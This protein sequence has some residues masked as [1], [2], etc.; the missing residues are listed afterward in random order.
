MPEKEMPKIEDIIKHQIDFESRLDSIYMNSKK[1]LTVLRSEHSE[2]R[3]LIISKLDM[4]TSRLLQISKL[5]ESYQS[6]TTNLYNILS[7]EKDAIA[8]YNKIELIAIIYRNFK[9]VRDLSDKLLNLEADIGVYD[10]LDIKYDLRKKHW[11]AYNFEEIRYELQYYCKDMER[12]SYLSVVRKINV[13]DRVIIDFLAEFLILGDN[14]FNLLNEDVLKNVE[15][16]IEFEENR[17][18]IT[19]QINVNCEGDIVKEELKRLNYRYE[20]RKLKEIKKKFEDSIKGGIKR[21]VDELYKDG[22][23]NLD[24]IFEDFEKYEK[25]M[26][27]TKQNKEEIY[28]DWASIIMSYNDVIKRIVDET[29]LSS[30]HILYILGFVDNFYTELHFKFNIPKENF[31]NTILGDCEDKFVEIYITNVTNTFFTY[32][33]NIKNKEIE[34]F[35]LRDAAPI[36]DE[37]NKYVSENVITLLCLI[38]E[39]LDPIA[40]NKRIFVCVS[41]MIVKF[42]KTFTKEITK[43]MNK[44]YELCSKNKGK[45]G[46]EEYVIMVG[47]SGLKI[48]QY[49]TTLPQSQNDELKELSELFL[50]LTKSSNQIL[51]SFI[52]N[53]CK[54]ALDQVFTDNWYNEDTTRVLILTLEDFI[55]DYNSV[56]SSFM[57][58]L[59]IDDL[60]NELINSYIK[61][62]LRNRA[63]I[64]EDAGYR[65]LKDCEKLHCLF[66]KYNSDSS[67]S[68]LVKIAPLLGKCGIEIFVVELKSLL[69]MKPDV[70]RDVIK[71]IVKKKEE[72]TDEEKK[73]YL[74]AVK[75]CFM[76]FQNERNTIFGSMANK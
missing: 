29:A 33:E 36:L 14:A 54:A 2:S 42:S 70:K 15:I 55:S 46:F 16:I 74:D 23:E 20:N 64:Y 35:M 30:R 37:D 73:K 4:N 47:N 19:K 59:F 1:R 65:L 3:N 72:L 51:S 28:I 68:S 56:M 66:K 43:V 17:D 27:I 18:F 62:L 63:K 8:D 21:R 39:Q 76:E 12:A 9:K 45:L 53:T 34:M 11:M 48:T 41:G 69:M 25:F 75:D 26:N 61:Q 38:K 24:V 67:F 32:I 6:N 60:V 7:D 22:L 50:N 10:S 52:I 31:E 13:L 5:K 58:F 57:Y 49:V 40:F 71:S 44:E